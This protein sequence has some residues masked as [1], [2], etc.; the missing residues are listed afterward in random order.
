MVVRLLSVQI[1]QFWEVIKYALQQV[2]RFGVDE[3]EERYNKIL[4]A[5]LNDKSQCLMMY[6]EGAVKAVMITEIVEDLVTSKRVLNI[7][8]LY[9]F[10]AVGN[11]TWEDNFKLLTDLATGSGCYKITFETNNAR[12]ESLG[13]M[14]GFTR[15]SINMEYEVKV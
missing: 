3:T 14:V 13:K 12:V 10:K 9:A 2:E 4:A 6:E 8:C 1:P 7:R 5:L 15:K 11:E